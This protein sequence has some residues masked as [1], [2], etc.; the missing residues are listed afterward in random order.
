[1]LPILPQ[2]LAALSLT[3]FAFAANSGLYLCDDINFGGSCRWLQ[4]PFGQCVS[5]DGD[6]AYKVSS[7]GPDKGNWC[8]LYANYGCTGKEYQLHWPG[9]SR[10]DLD[11]YSDQ[12]GSYNCAA[13]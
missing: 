9:Q 10:M 3:S 8:T 5:L 7:A 4:A 11:G 13:E 12:A 6:L 2:V 1:M